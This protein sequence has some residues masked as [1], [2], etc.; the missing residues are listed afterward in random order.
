MY[1][2]KNKHQIFDVKEKIIRIKMLSKADIVSLIRTKRDFPK[3][4]SIRQAWML[5]HKQKPKVTVEEF[6][7]KFESISKEKNDLNRSLEI[8]IDAFFQYE[9]NQ[10]GVRI[11]SFIDQNHE[12]I[13][14]SEIINRIKRCMCNI[15]NELLVNQTSEMENDPTNQDDELGDNFINHDFM[16]EHEL[17]EKTKITL[18][19]I[20]PFVLILIELGVIV[21]EDID[22]LEHSSFNLPQNN[23]N[24]AY[25]NCLDFEESIQKDKDIGPQI[26]VQKSCT[27]NDNSGSLFEVADS[28]FHIINIDDDHFN[29]EN[30]NQ[31]NT[32]SKIDMNVCQNEI[33]Y[34]N[35]EDTSND[36]NADFMIKPFD[37]EQNSEKRMVNNI[38]K[39]KS[40][41]NKRRLK[42]DESREMRRK[43]LSNSFEYLN[44]LREMKDSLI[45]SISEVANQMK[46]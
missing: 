46:S 4:F 36:T 25:I 21:V 38:E 17:S 19:R 37:N 23:V 42:W 28:N 41:T 8:N 32:K 3:S 10:K 24:I 31:F 33:N 27:Q 2:K 40:I 20:Q 43:N 30:E 16:T 34:S 45:R 29:I 1:R 39:I 6:V 12:V 9:I 5:I 18:E 44:R 13:K 26:E 7:K 15:N 22:I 11:Y 14:S 35:I